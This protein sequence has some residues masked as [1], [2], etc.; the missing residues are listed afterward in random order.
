[1]PLPHVRTGIAELDAALGTECPGF[2]RG[3]L[4]IVCGG[5]GTGK[6]TLVRHIAYHAATTGRQRVLLCDAEGTLRPSRYSSAIYELGSDRPVGVDIGAHTA[7][8][9]YQQPNDLPE[10]F[11]SIRS[12]VHRND[13]ILADAVNVLDLSPLPGQ[14]PQIAARARFL[15][16]A[17]QGLRLE[18]CALVLVF[19]NPRNG[20][21]E[22]G[23]H[24]LLV[25][26]SARLILDLSRSSGGVYSGRIAK[27]TWSVPNEEF[28]FRYGGPSQVIAV[29]KVK[30]IDR[31]KIPTR[32]NRED[33]L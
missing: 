16:S 31:S 27:T 8:F 3:A 26:R 21:I 19:Q 25:T 6:S 14:A 18:N 11:N 12:L 29:P 1:M 5:T 13:L 24:S 22:Q 32:F 17:V 10:L 30:T 4:T 23:R 9:D 28:E 2:P 33:P 15:G 7:P 20:P